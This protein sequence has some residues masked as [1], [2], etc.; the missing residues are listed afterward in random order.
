VFLPEWTC[1]GT[2]QDG[3]LEYLAG[4]PRGWYTERCP[5]RLP[6]NA[7][8]AGDEGEEEEE[9]GPR[10]GYTERCPCRL[11]RSAAAAGDEGEE[12]EEEGPREGY[13]ERCPC[14]LP[15]SA[16]AAGDEGEEE[17]EE[18][19]REGRRVPAEATTGG[20]GGGVE[21]EEPCGEAPTAESRGRSTGRRRPDSGGGEDWARGKEGVRV[22]PAWAV[23][24]PNGRTKQPRAKIEVG[25]RPGVEGGV[26]AGFWA[27]KGALREG[28]SSL[29]SVLM[30]VSRY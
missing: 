26:P 6:R 20:A 19:P 4:V 2:G 1:N 8:A 29:L 17:E 3:D 11:P 25:V 12:E 28:L 27:P 15:R 14:R 16:T 13:T 5:C 18:G 10:E 24:L 9:E 30:R 23:G 7:A 22:A 21:G